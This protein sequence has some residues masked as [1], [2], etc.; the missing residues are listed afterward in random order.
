MIKCLHPLHCMTQESWAYV[1]RVGTRSYIHSVAHPHHYCMRHRRQLSARHWCSGWALHRLL[2]C[3]SWLTALEA[4]MLPPHLKSCHLLGVLAIPARIRTDKTLPCRGCSPNSPF[5]HLAHIYL[6]EFRLF[7]KTKVLVE[8]TFWV[9]ANLFLASQQVYNSYP[10]AKID[11]Q[12]ATP[13]TKSR[14]PTLEY[15]V[16]S[17]SVSLVIL[18]KADKYQMF[19]K[20]EGPFL[21]HNLQISEGAFSLSCHLGNKARCHCSLPPSLLGSES[22]CL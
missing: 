14:T 1:A 9:T 22:N 18:H 17:F 12:K 19:M 5:L 16:L 6:L 2:Y 8:V 13:P 3:R 21:R 7:S 20:T 10:K 15:D 11:P 4:S